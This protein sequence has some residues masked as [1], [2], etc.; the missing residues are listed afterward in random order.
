MQSQPSLLIY[1]QHSTDY[2]VHKKNRNIESLDLESPNSRYFPPCSVFNSTLTLPNIPSPSGQRLSRQ[3]DHKL[4]IID[5]EKLRVGS[6]GTKDRQ[7]E[8]I[9]CNDDEQSDCQVSITASVNQLS[10]DNDNNEGSIADDTDFNKN[11]LLI[12]RFGT[13][14]GSEHNNNTEPLTV[15]QNAPIDLRY[16][17]NHAHLR[18]AM[19]RD[20]VKFSLPSLSRDMRRHT[21]HEV[22]R[23]T[24]CQ[25]DGESRASKAAVQQDLSLD[26]RFLM[27]TEVSQGIFTFM[28][29]D[30][31]REHPV[32]FSL[33]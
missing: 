23:I 29:M 6:V 18:T 5:L 1:H 2:T 10:F 19:S 11:L 20:K 25:Q 31:L 9:A 14:T 8:S 30:R 26:P 4:E 28:L 21:V 32:F 33:P 16:E 15:I 22:P 13:T 17:T 12:T 3:N 27:P 7:M 24:V